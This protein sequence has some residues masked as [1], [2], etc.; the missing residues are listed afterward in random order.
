MIAKYCPTKSCR[1][2]TA[3]S[4]RTFH[5][6]P[7]EFVNSMA[8]LPA[9]WDRGTFSSGG[10][11]TPQQVLNAWDAEAAAFG[12]INMT[13]VIKAEIAKFN[14]NVILTFDPRHGTSCNPEHRAAGQ[15]VING[16]DAAS[17]TKS[18]VFLLTTRRIDPPG[19][20]GL[21]PAAPMDRFSAVY[22]ANDYVPAKAMTGWAY[23][24]YLMSIYPT[25]FPSG[26]ITAVNS[27]PSVDRTTAFLPLDKYIINDQRYMTA[28]D[29]RVPT[30]GGF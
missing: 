11:R 26:D 8:A 3:T 16:V 7:N 10:D 15:A 12:L 1:V 25:Q 14:P 21:I 23:L 5:P 18:N 13:N 9:V 22:N 6:N 28:N 29:S 27:S 4:N 19:Y 30:C 20:S 17:F 2:V 24:A